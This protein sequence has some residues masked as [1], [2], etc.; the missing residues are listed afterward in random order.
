M[1]KPILLLL[2][3]TV[4]LTWT[5]PAHAL[6]PLDDF[7]RG[8]RTH[9]PAN[10]EAAAT[11]TAAEAQ[12]G[13][14]L[15]HALPALSASGSYTR[16]QYEVTFGTLTMVPQ[17]QLDGAVAL[18]VPLVDLAR[19]TRVSAANRAAEAAAHRQA[20][21][22]RET[23]AQVAQLYYQLAANLALV[24]AARKALEVVQLNQKLT[25][26][27]K[28]AGTNTALDV[29]RARAEVER[30]RQLLTAAELEAKLSARALS[31]RT[32]L[33]ADV[34]AGPPL[35]DDL[36][37]EPALDSFLTRTSQTPEVRAASSTRAAAETQALAQKLTLLPSL[38]GT[39]S[40]RYT[41]A[42]G[43]LNGHHEA[44][45]AALSLSWSFDLATAPAIRARTAE[46]AAARARES[47]TQL[48]TGD[49]IFRAWS[50]VDADI[51]RSRSARAQSAVSA[52]AA[53][54]ARTRYRSGVS[55]QLDLIQADRDAFAAEAGRIQADA[56][57]LN[58]RRQLRLLV[59]E[60]R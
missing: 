6:Q 7:I 33:V 25:E 48:D 57:L 32:G 23:E 1:T 47:Q 41:N 30:Q 20:A 46:A 15:G 55:T 44:F 38:A 26:D 45:T 4:A 10:Q 2:P 51:A 36:Q 34:S 42:T 13:E 28:T 14:A 16:N 37:A 40:E 5:P 12:A 54:I 22:A 53:D 21:V 19:F 9:H 27:A 58:A 50:T 43:F 18:S 8:A 24:D 35:A 11:R 3:L 17:N 31:S 52:R 59:G 60:G 29:D 56:D 49:A 39:A